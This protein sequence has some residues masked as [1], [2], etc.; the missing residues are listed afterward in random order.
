MANTD[1]ITY[2]TFNGSVGIGIKL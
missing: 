2:E 1:T